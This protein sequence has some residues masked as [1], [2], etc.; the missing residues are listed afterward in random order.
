MSD[1]GRFVY[2]PALTE[3]QYSHLVTEIQNRALLNGL[4]VKRLAGTTSPHSGNTEMVTTAPI[5]FFP[6]LFSRQNFDEAKAIQCAYNELY[7][8]ISQDENWIAAVVAE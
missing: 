5:T 3:V 6:S 4:A 1:S 8:T 7:A 2:P